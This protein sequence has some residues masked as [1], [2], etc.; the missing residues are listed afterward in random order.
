MASRFGGT[1]FPKT[2][3]YGRAAFVDVLAEVARLFRE[4]PDKIDNNRK[5]L[6][7]RLADTARPAG[8]VVI[9]A[10]ELDSAAAS[11]GRIFDQANGGLRGAPKFPQCA[12][13][14]FL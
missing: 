4:E 12:M 10:H 3:R 9:G 7:E 2:S 13:L 5:A 11:I 1:Y 6:M 14:E 8:R